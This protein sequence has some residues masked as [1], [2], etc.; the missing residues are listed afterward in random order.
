MVRVLS[1]YPPHDLRET[2]LIIE[3]NN[4]T[5][6]KK[7]IFC[8]NTLVIRYSSI[9]G[10]NASHLG[11]NF[12]ASRLL[13]KYFDL[14]WCVRY[15]KFHLR[16]SEKDFQFVDRPWTYLW[17][18]AQMSSP[19]LQMVMAGYG[20]LARGSDVDSMVV[21]TGLLDQSLLML[22]S[23]RKQKPRLVER[24]ASQMSLSQVV[25][26]PSGAKYWTPWMEL[27]EQ[28]WLSSFSF[29]FILKKIINSLKISKQQ[30]WRGYFGCVDQVWPKEK[31]VAISL[32]MSDEQVLIWESRQATSAQ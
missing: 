7:N 19:S 25:A 20:M 32:I 2:V 13:I 9:L 15:Y 1:T 5:I 29:S 26:S 14:D 27:D 11:D 3:R 16:W 8:F 30:I 6:S 23:R 31:L 24:A 12:E 22:T 28:N 18:K 10:P 4:W 21:M 17:L